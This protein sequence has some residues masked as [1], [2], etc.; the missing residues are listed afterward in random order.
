M[1]LGTNN[2]TTTTGAVYIPE[3]WSDEIIAT[4]KA[5]LVVAD[6]ITKFEMQGKKGDT[7][8]VPRKGPFN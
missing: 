2:T 8:H 5:N 3:L 1:A 4:F 6:R 7:I